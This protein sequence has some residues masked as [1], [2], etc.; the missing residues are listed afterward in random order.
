MLRVCSVVPRD[1]K[2][3]LKGTD[4]AYQD[5]DAG[6]CGRPGP[7]RLQGVATGT[8]LVHVQCIA[9]R[10]PNV[11]P[12]RMSAY[13]LPCSGFNNDCRIAATCFFLVP[14]ASISIFIPRSNTVADLCPT[15]SRKLGSTVLKRA[16]D[17]TSDGEH[18]ID[19]RLLDRNPMASRKAS[20]MPRCV[21]R[22]RRRLLRSQANTIRSAG[23]ISPRK[24]NGRSPIILRIQCRSASFG[25]PYRP[26]MPNAWSGSHCS[27]I[28]E[29][30]PGFVVKITGVTSPSGPITEYGDPRMSDKNSPSPSCS[31]NHAS[32]A[33]GQSLLMDAPII[34]SSQCFHPNHGMADPNSLAHKVSDGLQLVPHRRNRYSAWCQPSYCS[35]PSQCGS[36]RDGVATGTQLVHVQCIARRDRMLSEPLVGGITIC[37]PVS[38]PG[39]ET[40]H[41]Y[42]L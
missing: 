32:M 2:T 1:D 30:T 13:R 8:Q 17:S 18:G 5:H 41:L 11:G 33:P 20:F 22:L 29:T 39:H 21:I 42:I 27:R 36:Q 6:L 19:T 34:R 24:N 26:N 15:S 28:A 40:D 7:D 16:R 3:S 14:I 23:S 31:A 4:H 38:T 10:G 37:V 9:R 35:L 12:Q 25:R